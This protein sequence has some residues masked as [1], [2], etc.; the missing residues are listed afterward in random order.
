VVAP[1]KVVSPSLSKHVE[2]EFVKI[3]S[4]LNV[5]VFV[6]VFWPPKDAFPSTVKVDCNSVGPETFN[7]WYIFA[8]LFIVVNPSTLN[9]L[10]ICVA[11]PQ[12]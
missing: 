1:L 11:N 10:Y 5:L 3:I 9:V 7:V 2:P 8:E 6:K 4:L 12:H